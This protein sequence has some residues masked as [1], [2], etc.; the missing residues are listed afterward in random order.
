MKKAISTVLVSMLA[1]SVFGGC[2][3]LTAPA[4]SSQP[5][6]APTAPAQQASAP[7]G[8][9]IVF[10]VA[11]PTVQPLTHEAHTM[12]CDDI[13]A[14]SGGKMKIERY[15]DGELVSS[16]QDANV[17]LSNNTIQ[18]S[19]MSEMMA[20]ASAP[21]IVNWMY[22]PFAFDSKEHCQR[23]FKAIGDEITEKTIDAYNVRLIW[24][25]MEMRRPRVIMSNK[26]IYSASDFNRMVMR[27]PKTEGAVAAF[28]AL[29]AN[30]ITS[31]TEEIYG[32]MQNNSA[33]ACDSPISL[34]DSYSIQEV[35]KYAVLTFHQ[36]AWR[37]AHIN[38]DFW[39]S[40]TEEQRG[41]I[42][43]GL[44]RG[45]DYYTEMDESAEDETIEKWEKNYGTTVIRPEQIDIEGI[46]KV[47]TE[48]VLSK[49]KDKWD[50][51]KWEL[52]ESLRD[53]K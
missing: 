7:S 34:L 48:G 38:E 21:E 25:S 1:L 50:Y 37:V 44:K 2:A 18:M 43:A 51:S 45:F 23:F 13:E 29:G 15:L 4:S 17:A 53:N 52:L 14:L 3:K 11:F 36:H 12:I 41:W 47:A 20:A 10:K 19:F 30:P 46:K 28:E 8:P 27:L 6:A 49:Y 16:D 32:L 24:D 5:A 26:P 9:E 39:Q 35:A 42:L 33:Q 40:L 31:T 22:V